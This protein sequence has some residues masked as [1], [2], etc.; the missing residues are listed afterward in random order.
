MHEKVEAKLAEKTKESRRYSSGRF[1]IR[2]SDESHTTLTNI[3]QT[4]RDRYTQ[5]I[6]K[7]NGSVCLWFVVAK[8]Q[9]EQLKIPKRINGILE[10]LHDHRILMFTF[11]HVS[12]CRSD[13]NLWNEYIR[14]HALYLSENN[15]GVQNTI[16]TSMDEIEKSWV[17]ELQKIETRILCYQYKNGSVEVTETNWNEFKQLITSFVRKKLEFSVDH[18]GFRDQ[19][20]DNSALQSYAKGGMTYTGPA[21]PIMDLINT[22]NKN[23]ISHDDEWLHNNPTHPLGAIHAL[24]KKKFQNTVGRGGQ[25]SI[26][27]AYFELKRAPFGL[28]YNALSAFVLGF[29]LRDI[30]KKNYQWT[31]G[32]DTRPLDIDTLAQVI[33][34]VVKDDWTPNKISQEKLICKLSKETKKFI[35]ATPL[36]FGAAPIPDSSVESVLLQIATR[37]EE[38]S[39]RVPLWVLPEYVHETADPKADAIKAILMEICTA[40]TISSKSKVEDRVSAV[41]RAWDMIAKDPEIISAIAGFIRKENFLRAFEIYVDEESPALSSL[42]GSIGDLSHEYCRSILERCQETSGWLWKQADISREIDEVLCEYKV[43]QLASNLCGFNGFVSY[44]SVFDA[45]KTA[46]TTNNHL[47]KQLIESFYPSLANFLMALQQTGLASDI[48]QALDESYDTIKILFFDSKKAETLRLL[49]SKLG[50]VGIFDTDL[51]E[52]LNEMQGGFGLDENS[53]VSS[54]RM[55]I[56]EFAKKS[57]I[58]KIKSQWVRVS[59]ASSTAEWSLKNSLPAKYIFGN[60][61]DAMDL[62]SAVANPENFSASRLESLL[63]TLESI[64]PTEIADCQERLAADIIPHRYKKFQINA[65][66]LIDFLI[67]EHGKQPNN[68][69]ASPDVSEFIKSQYKGAIAPQVREKI[70][71][72]GAEE[73]KIKLL[74]LA[75]DNPELGLLFLEA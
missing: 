25:Q 26:R 52:I 23:G 14:Q 2:V 48:K 63:E 18:L 61:P 35:E 51:L 58:T 19:H 75:D 45:L 4:T 3:T 12:F 15:K 42:A 6:N 5:N 64:E 71:S 70:R 13:K 65:S 8:D 73:L 66:S 1:D 59:G 53:F 62:L 68:W 28:R 10:Q 40:L 41:N 72:K 67:R 9:D 69:P 22:L 39:A 36:M 17:N 20:F 32:K 33:E 34:A 21:G 50:D 60:R 47:P 7:D 30:L 74:E 49:K 16:R 11:P 55:K 31:D 37:V 27:I 44:S 43:V 56:D 57:V 24:F 46:V 29:C 54:M 38:I